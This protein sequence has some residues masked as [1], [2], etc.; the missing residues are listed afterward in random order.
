MMEQDQKLF[1]SEYRLLSI[2]WENEPVQS[3]ELCKICQESLGWKRTT[4]YTVLK[5]LCNKGVL[6][7]ESAIVTSIDKREEVQR[8]EGQVVLDKAFGGSLPQFIAAFLG[9]Q[10]IS[11]AEAQEIRDMIDLYQSKREKDR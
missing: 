5:K 9:E 4:T 6:Q 2:V 1:D 10:G 3:G 11:D 7:N 8:Q